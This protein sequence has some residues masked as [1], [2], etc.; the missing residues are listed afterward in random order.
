LVKIEKPKRRIHDKEE[1][2]EH[3]DK[4]AERIDPIIFKLVFIL[5]LI[6]VKLN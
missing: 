3:C 1:M 6:L 2:S 5:N 4:N